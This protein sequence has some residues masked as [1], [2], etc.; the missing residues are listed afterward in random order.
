MCLLCG[1]AAMADDPPRSWNTWRTREYG[2]PEGWHAGNAESPQA[3][4]R[5]KR[6][7]R[8]E[9]GR[10]AAG[11]SAD[12]VVGAASPPGARPVLEAES[13]PQRTVDALVIEVP[14]LTAA[15]APDGMAQAALDPVVE[16]AQRGR[17]DFDRLRL[18]LGQQP[19][20]AHHML[21]LAFDHEDDRVVP[22]SRV[23]A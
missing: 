15:L 1:G 10:A 13:R 21:D 22:D 11:R 7:E 16:A 19:Q 18:I 20:A 12:H 4:E 23:R 17:P 8:G 2:T 14:A 5:E 3:Q 9:P 6:G